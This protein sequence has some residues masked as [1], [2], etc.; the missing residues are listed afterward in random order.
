MDNHDIWL[1]A[2][3]RFQNIAK[4]R[5]YFE[6]ICMAKIL[7]LLYNSYCNRFLLILS[8][9]VNKMMY[10]IMGRNSIHYILGWQPRIEEGTVFM[11]KCILSDHHNIS[12]ALMNIWEN[13]SVPNPTTRHGAGEFLYNRCLIPYP[14]TS[15]H[16]WLAWAPPRMHNI[17][18]ISNRISWRCGYA[19]VDSP[20]RHKGVTFVNIA[21]PP[22]ER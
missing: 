15:E 2:Y 14:P 18:D 3:Q 21:S 7:I 9:G 5:R 8:C 19:I 12:V 20:W 17:S 4:P 16:R 1:L 13:M 6:Y 11:N 22:H 10:D